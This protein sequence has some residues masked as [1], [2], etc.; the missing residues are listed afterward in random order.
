MLDGM[1]NRILMELYDDYE[2]DNN[3]KQVIEFA[4]KTFPSDG[5]DKLFVG[6]VFIMFT[7]ASPFKPR[8]SCTREALESIVL[9]AKEKVGN[10]NLLAFYIDRVNTHKKVSSYLYKIVKDPNLDKYADLILDYLNHFKPN[11]SLD[12]KNCKIFNN[13]LDKIIINYIKEDNKEELW[14]LAEKYENKINL[15]RIADY[16]IKKR[17]NYYICELISLVGEYLNLNNIFDK[18]IATKDDEF[19]FLIAKNPIINNVIPES[20]LQKLNNYLENGK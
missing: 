20:C 1:I 14:N 18:I 10:S 5:T 2:K 12:V 6:C 15:E 16:Y 9:M 17:D 11:W 19:I 4:K 3:L 8:Y 13:Y 7:T